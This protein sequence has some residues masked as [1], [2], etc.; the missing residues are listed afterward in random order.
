MCI[1]NPFA[2]SSSSIERFDIVIFEGPEE[3]KKLHN[4]S[5]E[6]RYLKRVVGLPNEKIEIKNGRIFI[7]GNLLVE[8][9][10]VIS[11]ETDY[12]KDFPAMTIPEDEYFVLGDNR[13]ESEDSRFWKKPTIS[14]KDIYSKV[15]EI[16]KDFYNK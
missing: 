6:I 8:P 14:K 4:I 15:I 9:Y 12:K 2:Y 11:D 5:G 13:P 10:Q 1:T 3:S 16:K 7:N